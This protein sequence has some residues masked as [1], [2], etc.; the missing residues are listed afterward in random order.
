MNG[1]DFSNKLNRQSEIYRRNLEDNRES[2]KAELES[3]KEAHQTR[4]KNQTKAHK[5]QL[6]ELENNYVDSLDRVKTSQKQALKDKSDLYEDTIT[7]YKDEVSQQK[8]ENLKNWNKKL[9]ELKGTFSKNLSETQDGNEKARQALKTDY[10]RTVRD[11]R[12]NANSD[13]KEYMA[14]NSQDKKESDV[15]FRTEKNAIIEN[16]QKEKN[17]IREEE[18]A[19]RN[20]LK[21]NMLKDVRDSREIQDN[22]FIA[23]KNEQAEKFN[24]LTNNLNER[25]DNEII[26]RE[27]K[28]IDAHQESNRK[29]NIAFTE[30]FEDAQ[31][32]FNKDLRNLEYKQ[33]V[34]EISKGKQTQKIQQDYRDSLKAQI[35]KQRETQMRERFE[36]E[37]TYSKRLDDTVSSYQN[38]LRE[39]NIATGERITDMEAEFAEKNRKQRV[40]NK[41]ERAKLSEDHQVAMKYVEDNNAKRAATAQR[42]A[43]ERVQA[44][45]ENFNIS[46]ERAQEQ[47]DQNF[48]VT[49]EA[50]LEDKRQLERR[51]HEQNSQQ[52]AFIK[53]VY[54][55][56]IE[57]LT[58]GYEKR[59]HALNVQNKLLQQNSNDTVKDIIRKTNFEIE[60]QRKAAQESAANQVR[61]ERAASKEKQNALQD[62]IR[63][64]EA[65]FTEKMNE[66]T[67]A[68]RK[69][70]KDIQFTMEQKLKSEAD[71][72][73][74]II[75]QNNKFMARE[76][77]RLKMASE[78]EKQRL[79]TQYEEQ[80]KQLKD[81]YKERTNEIKQYNELNRA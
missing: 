64:L 23:G 54:N 76:F 69:K 79:V 43:N 15:Q 38:T 74:D 2:H 56:K 12:D 55:E 52:N 7:N 8:R 81:V 35:D 71:R 39:N 17:Q 32:K 18:L 22:R 41:Q 31:A 10:D 30:R 51:L 26:K 37:D 33:R 25:V 42:Q 40:E 28:L 60:R 14:N 29:Q 61:L 80:I 67:L 16:A 62:K 75:D 72:Y 65:N 11:I 24:K 46:L 57:K 59:I 68:N 20:F 6:R 45:K 34:K 70:V 77:Q 53:D 4:E 66:Q 1:I 36:V 3:L 5:K 13:L 78:L 73:Q 58:A 50:M 27:N 19:K 21:R 49:R 48:Q 47:S 9:S 63:N 44:L